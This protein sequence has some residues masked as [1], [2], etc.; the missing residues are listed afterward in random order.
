MSGEPITWEDDGERQPPADVDSVELTGLV[1][2]VAAAALLARY[3][4]PKGNRH[5]LSLALGGA[6]ARS[7]WEVA[8]IEAFL[9]AVVR[10][11][12]DPRPADRV[13]CARDAAEAVADGQQAYGFPKL[14]EI[15]GDVIA[16]K[17]AEWLGFALGSGAAPGGRVIHCGPDLTATAEAAER[18]LAGSGL[19]LFRRDTQLVRPVTLE[20]RGANDQPIQTVGLA[21]ISTVMMRS[22]MEQCARFEKFDARQKVWIR[23]KPPED[24]AELI[25]ART[26]YW[27]FPQVR[28]VL[29]APSLRPDGSLLDQPGYDA[30]TGMYLIDAAADA[31]H[32]GPADHARRQAG[33]RRPRQPA[34]RISLA[35][36]R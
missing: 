5:D 25:L 21:Q 27:P 1:S 34:G 32:P 33:T 16:D 4:P 9:D 26:G 23:C 20:A 24:V 3:W 30:A 8:A 2:R 10:C 36:R 28:G 15:L 12:H 29:A 17:L 14:K 11:A 31:G 19:P 7:G 18:A 6:L 22:F 13:R 35:G